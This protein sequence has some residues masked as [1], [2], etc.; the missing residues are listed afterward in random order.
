M[1]T[2]LQAV[3]QA[4]SF[5]QCWWP[6]RHLRP[7]TH[8]RW[9]EGDFTARHTH[10]ML[11]KVI[12][13]S[14][15]SPSSLTYFSEVPRASILCGPSRS[16]SRN[17]QARCHVGLQLCLQKTWI[18]LDALICVASHT[19]SKLQIMNI[20]I[21]PQGKLLIFICKHF[22]VCLWKMRALKITQPQHHSLTQRKDQWFLSFI[23]C[24]VRVQ[25]PLIKLY[26]LCYMIFI[27][28][29]FKRRSTC[30]V[31]RSLRSLSL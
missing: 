3:H 13:G 28:I 12:G 8:W 11:P 23:Q 26:L 4:W 29:I 9:S 21:S 31:E 18:T 1:K 14:L 27:K 30:A 15:T 22:R 10:K 7:W 16:F 6:D 19:H 25:I 2:T 20:S 5:L 24:P 17:K